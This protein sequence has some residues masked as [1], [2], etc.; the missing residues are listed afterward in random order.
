MNQ[1][2]CAIYYH[3]TVEE[4]LFLFSQSSL[5]LHNRVVDSPTAHGC[6]VI[7]TYKTCSSSEHLLWF[8][9]EKSH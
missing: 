9:F 2:D 1:L 3:S 6:I 5:L 7:F 4:H 8:T